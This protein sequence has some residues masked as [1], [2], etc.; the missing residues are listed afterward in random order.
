MEKD[1]VVLGLDDLIDLIFE[2]TCFKGTDGEEYPAWILNE[3]YPGGSDK[4]KKE[5]ALK[6]IETLQKCLEH[7][8]IN[9]LP[10]E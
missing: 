5:K 3:K 6:I 4:H 2:T 8:G 7:H 9:S 10:M 1:G